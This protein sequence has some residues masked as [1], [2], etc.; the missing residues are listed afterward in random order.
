MCL[1]KTL[2]LG[3]R[4]HVG[5]CS[6]KEPAR[7]VTNTAEEKHMQ[8][9][10]VSIQFGAKCEPDAATREIKTIGIMAGEELRF[11]TNGATIQNSASGQ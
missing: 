4:N 1:K 6:A 2:F 8:M 9:L 5:A 3:A 10:S 11:A 7:H